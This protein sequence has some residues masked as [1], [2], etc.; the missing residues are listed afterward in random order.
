MLFTWSPCA[1]GLRPGFYFLVNFF[2]WKHSIMVFCQGNAVTC[3]WQSQKMPNHPCQKALLLGRALPSICAW[4]RQETALNPCA[5][6]VIPL[7]HTCLC[8]HTF[9]APSWKPGYVQ[10]SAAFLFCHFFLKFD[11]AVV[12]EAATNSEGE[13]M[14]A[15]VEVSLVDVS[16]KDRFVLLHCFTTQLVNL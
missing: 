1:A 7:G 5:P 4:V 16:T 8:F 13:D 10:V 2:L 14:Y 6:T 12:N 9:Y 11:S 3:C 15:T